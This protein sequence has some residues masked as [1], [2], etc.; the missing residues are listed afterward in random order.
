MGK[1]RLITSQSEFKIW[2]GRIRDWEWQPHIHSSHTKTWG[3]NASESSKYFLLLLF[4][5]WSLI[6]ARLIC[7]LLCCFSW[8]RAIYLFFMQLELLIRLETSTKKRMNRWKAVSQF[9]PTNAYSFYQHVIILICSWKA[10]IKAYTIKLFSGIY[11]APCNSCYNSRLYAVRQNDRNY[12]IAFSVESKCTQKWYYVS[13]KLL[14]WYDETI[15]EQ[16]NGLCVRLT[17]LLF[18]RKL[19]RA[20][21]SR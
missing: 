20:W 8:S 10:R 13:H 9:D 17:F 6:F 1:K 4:H 3:K 21:S 2:N 15:Y 16:L 12:S 11:R 14:D 7:S 18:G 5:W 19:F